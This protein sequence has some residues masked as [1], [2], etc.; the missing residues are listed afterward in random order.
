L[1]AIAGVFQTLAYVDY[2]VYLSRGLTSDLLRYT[3][4]TSVIKATCILIGSQ[5]GV[6]GV[7]AGYAIAPAIEWPLS[8]WWLARRTP[9]PLR[10]LNLGALRILVVITFGGVV[11]WLIADA[12]QSTPEA[13]Q[14]V[15]SILGGGIA[16]LALL[17]FVPPFKQDARD[18][19]AIGSMVLAAR[20]ARKLAATRDASPPTSAVPDENHQSE[21]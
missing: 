6:I 19:V 8:F 5:W 13:L 18:V 15:A 1:L 16:Y 20:R 21:G 12:L 11:A 9:L 2:W 7:A 17:W 14:F 10:R 4:V 3:I